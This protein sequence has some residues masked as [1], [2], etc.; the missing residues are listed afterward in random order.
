M[1]DLTDVI[2]QGWA[3]ADPDAPEPT[4]SYF[5]DLLGQHPGDPHALFAY[6]SALDFASREAKAAPA[7]QAL[8]QADDKFPGQA[9]VKV[10]LA[11]AGR[12]TW[13]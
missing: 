8:Q 4:V 1:S 3:T 2:Q 5:H 12:T 10:F 7:V 11:L 13:P 9:S 6:A